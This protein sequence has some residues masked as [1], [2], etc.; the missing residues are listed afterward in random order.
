MRFNWNQV[1]RQFVAS[2]RVERVLHMN[3]P[4]TARQTA[5]RLRSRWRGLVEV[6]S[7]GDKITIR[8]KAG[9]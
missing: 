7:A 2:G 6:S 4:A 8:R 5:W 9:R 3:S 1:I